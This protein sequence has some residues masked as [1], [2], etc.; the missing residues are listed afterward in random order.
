[1]ITLT[2]TGRL[3]NDP[4]IKQ[5]GDRQATSFGIASTHKTRNGSET[6]FVDVT[7]WGP[8]GEVAQKYMHKGDTITVVGKMLPVKVSDEKAYVK[9]DAHDFTLPPYGVHSGASPQAQSE[10]DDDMPF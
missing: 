10:A 4:Q 6:T 2:I 5:I 8:R 3:T 9:I 7:I 1:M